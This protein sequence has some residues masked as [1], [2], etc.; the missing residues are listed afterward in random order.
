MSE[1]GVVTEPGMVRLERILPGPID[2][3]WSY[4][5]DSEKRGTWLAT[6][7]IEPRVGGR[8]EHVWRNNAHTP[9]DDPAPAK[10]ADIAEYARMEGRVTA[11]DPPRRLAYTWEGGPAEGESEVTFE[12]SAR[13]AD[14]LLVLTHRRLVTRDGMLGVSSGWHAHLDVL[15]ARLAGRTPPGFWRTHAKLEVEYGRRIPAGA[16]RASSA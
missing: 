16:E 4:L 5:V 1:Y 3:V 11:Y 7:E 12:L 14:V 6:G 10:Y 15:A 13:G 2:R 9:D 8:V